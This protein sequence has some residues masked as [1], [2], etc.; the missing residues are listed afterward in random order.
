MAFELQLKYMN[1]IVLQ[2]KDMNAQELQFKYMID[3]ELQ[4]KDMNG[5]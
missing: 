2:L 3:I 4:L 1:D 5:I